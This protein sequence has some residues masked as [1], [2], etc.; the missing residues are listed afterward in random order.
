[1]HLVLEGAVAELTP[2]AG[3]ERASHSQC[4]EH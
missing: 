4:R 1:M 2:L 3:E